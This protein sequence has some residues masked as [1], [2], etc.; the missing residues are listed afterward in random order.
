MPLPSRFSAAEISPRARRGASSR[1]RC[2]WRAASIQLQQ[3]E[4]HFNCMEQPGLG[5][6]YLLIPSLSPNF[7]LS[8]RTR[9]TVA[10]ASAGDFGRMHAHCIS[11]HCLA[12]ISPS[13][14]PVP[15]NAP[16]CHQMS[17]QGQVGMSAPW[18]GDEAL[19]TAPWLP[20]G[21][22]Q[23]I[24]G[25]APTAVPSNTMCHL[26]H[27]GWR[28][29]QQRVFFPSHPTNLGYPASTQRSP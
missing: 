13:A 26:E 3:G 5:R 28:Q 18:N 23:D 20:L 27:P 24:P 11:P 1:P 2:C 14:S 7:T 6:L 8:A 29:T 17:G 12:D 4:A 16:K 10:C 9:G 22:V 15:P 21:V 19:T 25:V